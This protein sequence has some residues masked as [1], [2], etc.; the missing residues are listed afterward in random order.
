MELRQMPPVL[1]L[2]NHFAELSSIHRASAPANPHAVRL[3]P[4]HV[5]AL[6]PFAPSR[7]T[8]RTTRQRRTNGAAAAA[9]RCE[10]VA[11]LAG[12]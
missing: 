1:P 7:S 12:Q 4:T 5:G 10:P 6:F 2:H 8:N 11:L 3:A 9:P